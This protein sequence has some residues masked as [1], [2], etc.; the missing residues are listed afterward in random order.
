MSRSSLRYLTIFAALGISGCAHYARSPD[1]PALTEPALPNI[2]MAWEVAQA[3]IGEVEV[4]WIDRLADPV[5]S[6]LVREGLTHNRNLQAALAAVE[7]SR[8]LA[9]QARAPLLPAINY[10]LAGSEAGPI[11]GSAT[12]SYSSGVSLS[13]ELDVWGRVRA[14]RNATAYSLASAE[15]DYVASQYSLAASIATTYFLV[16][17][18]VLQQDVARKSLDALANTHRIVRAQREIGLADAYDESLS[19]ANLASAEATLAQAAGALRQAQRALEVL[20]GRYPA[21][22]IATRIDLPTVPATP[23]AGLPSELLA[24]RPDIVAAE[25]SVAAAFSN[26]GAVKATRLPTLSL[27]GSL[28]VSVGRIGDVLD[29]DNGIWSLASSLL[30]PLFD[31]GLRKAQVEEATASQRQ[32]IAVFAQTALNAFQEVENS[33]DQN[34]VLAERVT[35]LTQAASAQNR[36]FSLAQLRYREGETDL[37]DVLTVQT[38]TLNADSALVSVRRAQLDEWISLNL[39]LGG[40]W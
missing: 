10:S 24:R 1:L 28:D 11:R 29:I 30:G 21:S 22:A 6:E 19:N 5:L 37:L 25:M 13:W 15:A 2:P 38:N 26:V 23:T 14:A 31:A 3:R 35:A 8:A 20:L 17:E 9:R 16:I 40:G 4:G 18:S 7:Q 32:A 39:A 12:D 27:N 36:A 33:I 34:R